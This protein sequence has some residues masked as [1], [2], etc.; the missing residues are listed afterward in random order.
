MVPLIIVPNVSINTI[1]SEMNVN[2]ANIL[3]ETVYP[4]LNVCLVD[5]ITTIEYYPLLVDV[6]RVC[7]IM[8][9]CVLLVPLLVKL[10]IQL[11]PL[12]V[13][14]VLMVLSYQVLLV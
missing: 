7:L 5:M 2:H 10:V 3:V 6:N 9:L 14:L 12:I 8:V 1:C 4:L 11:Q 13:L